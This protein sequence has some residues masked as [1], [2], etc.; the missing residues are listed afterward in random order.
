M[1]RSEVRILGPLLELSRRLSGRQWI[2]AL[3]FLW[4]SM[5]GWSSTALAQG[6]VSSA[7]ARTAQYVFVIDDSGSMSKQT[8]GGP[9]ADPDRLSVFAVRSLLSMLDDADEVTVVRLN[10]PSD[11]EA[12]API[13]ALKTS[14][15]ARIRTPI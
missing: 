14:R 1:E 4:L 9:P 10:G 12:I 7:Q 11:S 13:S 6:E 15:G 3:G 2:F 8:R 5:F